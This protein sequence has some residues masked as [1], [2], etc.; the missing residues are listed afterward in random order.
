MVVLFNGVVDGFSEEQGAQLMTHG[1][2][3]ELGLCSGS[4]PVINGYVPDVVIK[5]LGNKRTGRD[6]S[7]AAGKCFVL[8]VTFIEDAG[9]CSVE[10][11]TGCVFNIING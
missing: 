11:I 3:Q 6:G 8:G 5:R 2:T 10:F 7:V 1:W 9:M 4:M